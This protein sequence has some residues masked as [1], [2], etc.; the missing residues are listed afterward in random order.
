MKKREENFDQSNGYSGIAKIMHWG[1]VLIFAYGIYKQVDDLSQLSNIALL[2]FEIF[3]ALGFLALLVLRFF[4]MKT[5][6]KSALPETS[7]A[8]QKVLAKLVHH[9]LYLSFA[10]IAVS[11][12]IIGGLY[13]FGISQGFFMEG[14]IGLHEIAVTVSYYLIAIHI[15]AAVYH[16]LL[17]DHVWSAMVPFWRE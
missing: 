13:Y 10:S 1:F 16:R 2:R 8:W 3:F 14:I 12:L 11:G 7:N 15:L 4:Y 9:G 6:Q 17:Q 5:T